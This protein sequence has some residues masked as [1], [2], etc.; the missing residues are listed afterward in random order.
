M[1]LFCIRGNGIRSK[2]HRK[3]Q[4]EI[5]NMVRFGCYYCSVDSAVFVCVMLWL[6]LLNFQFIRLGLE[7]ASFSILLCCEKSYILTVVVYCSR[8]QDFPLVSKFKD[9]S[10]NG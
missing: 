4:L 5:L 7:K 3:Y 9:T 2:I 10:E 1:P 8:S 6:L